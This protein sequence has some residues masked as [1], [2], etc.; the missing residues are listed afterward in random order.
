MGYI[1]KAVIITAA[2]LGAFPQSRDESQRYE[3]HVFGTV[4]DERDKKLDHITVCI[5][6]AERP[7]NGR[8]PCDKTSD[9]GA[10]SFIVRDVPDKYQVCAS[11]T[12]SVFV[13][14]G[15]KDPKH[16][17]VCSGVLNFPAKD[18]NIEVSLK[19]RPK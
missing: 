12:E 2:L 17:V 19:F 15:D 1:V 13:T 10:F 6:P 14:I 18:E 3:Y 16:R 5:L 11:T 4:R 7:I 9:A 8:I